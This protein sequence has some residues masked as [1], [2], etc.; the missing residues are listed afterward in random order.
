MVTSVKL[1]E[2]S[3]IVDFQQQ[4][5]QE[6]VPAFQD[7]DFCTLTV[8]SDIGDMRMIDAYHRFVK[9][10]QSGIPRAVWL[11]ENP[12]SPVAFPG[13]IDLRGHDY[14]HLLLN[15]G[16]SLFD[17]A[18]VVGYTMGNCDQLKPHHLSMYK[19]LSNLFFPKSYKFNSFHMRAFDFGILYGRKVPKRNIHTVDFDLYANRTV[20]EVRQIFGINL[21]D[22]ETLWH[23]EQLLLNAR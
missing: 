13:S 5:L 15:R 19:V 3:D 1:V 10:E 14:I 9:D 22:I 16:M 6:D 4:S 20:N 8:K 12:K 2:T 7:L 21:H 23:A 11:L 18:F 17:E